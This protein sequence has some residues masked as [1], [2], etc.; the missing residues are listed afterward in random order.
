MRYHS[1]IEEVVKESLRWSTTGVAPVVP[2]VPVLLHL[3]QKI[4]EKCSRS[5]D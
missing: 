2:V 3:S 5:S 4:V 1:D